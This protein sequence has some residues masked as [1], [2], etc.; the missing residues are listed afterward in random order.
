MLILNVS[1]TVFTVYLSLFIANKLLCRK[2]ETVCLHVFL[3][4][5][6]KIISS[7]ISHVKD[8]ESKTK[9]VDSNRHFSL[10]QKTLLLKWP[11]MPCQPK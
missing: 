7:F 8:L 2:V 3:S 11:E 4:F 5:K 9:T 10:P 1:L 6:I